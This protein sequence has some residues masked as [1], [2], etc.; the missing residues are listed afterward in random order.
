MS[1]T[2]RTPSG[3]QQDYPFTTAQNW[4]IALVCIAGAC[5]IVIPE[6]AGA[7]AD[8]VAALR[9]TGWIVESLLLVVVLGVA[10]RTGHTIPGVPR[11]GS[12]QGFR[13]LPF[14]GFVAFLI[15]S[16]TIV[17]KAF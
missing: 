11:R 17:F 15:V 2:R 7:S 3:V 5:L 8:T 4:L 16:W 9:A 10:F 1:D 13:P 14:L 6:R 12:G